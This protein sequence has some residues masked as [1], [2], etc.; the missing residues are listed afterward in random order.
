M[1]SEYRLDS[2]QVSNLSDVPEEGPATPVGTRSPYHHHSAAASSSAFKAAASTSSLA[3]AT[4]SVNGSVASASRPLVGPRSSSSSHRATVSRAT[5]ETTPA[6]PGTPRPRARSGSPTTLKERE[7]EKEAERAKEREA[8]KE[9]EGGERSKSSRRE[10][11]STKG[12]THAADGSLQRYRTR[13]YPR[14]PHHKDVPAVPATLMYW[15]PAPVHGTLPGGVRAH[16]VTVVDNTAWVF[17]GCD[18]RVCWR[19]VFCFNI[20][21]MQWSHP[22]MLGDIP[23]PCRAHTATLVDRRIIVFGGGEG[24]DYYNSLYILDTTTRRWTCPV[25]PE[26]ALLPPVRRAHTAVVYRGRLFIFGGGNGSEA[27]HDLWAIDVN[28]PPERMRWECLQEHGKPRPRG[29]HTTNLI[30]NV[31]VVF[32]GSDGKECFSDLWCLNL[33]TLLWSQVKLDQTYRRLSH[34]ATQ[35]GSYLFIMGGHDG[36]QYVSDLLFFNLVSLT[37][38]ERQVAGLTPSA[39]GYHVAF[40]ADSRLFVFGGFSGVEVYEDMHVLDLA[41]AAYL[42]QV[43]SFRIDVE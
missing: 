26:D 7:N 39:R 25:F 23:S 36:N 22:E 20:D 28:V 38:E 3:S 27:L 35:V 29:Y 14:L 21:T 37:F 13:H 30:G 19:D 2:P 11:R 17:G 43:T 5:L 42:P 4:A 40:L 24:P 12:T 31:M 10:G 8:P 33:D 18:E 34:T 15:S 32:G 41:G 1:P 9:R 16:T 6:A